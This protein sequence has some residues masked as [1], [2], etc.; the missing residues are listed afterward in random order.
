MVLVEK[1]GASIDVKYQNYYYPRLIIYKSEDVSDLSA[2][3]HRLP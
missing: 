2:R 1:M 3:P